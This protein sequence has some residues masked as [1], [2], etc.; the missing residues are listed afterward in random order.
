[1]WDVALKQ[2]IYLGEDSFIQRM[3]SLLEP[4]RAHAAEVPRS[5]RRTRPDSIQTYLKAYERDEAFVKACREGG[6][7]LSSI[8]REVGLSVSRVSRIVAACE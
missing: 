2:Q 6:H 5:Q 4:D 8:A 7:T 3:Q 1:M